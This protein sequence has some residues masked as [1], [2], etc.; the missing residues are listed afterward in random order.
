MSPMAISACL[1]PDPYLRTQ[2]NPDP[3]FRE[4]ED[5]VNILRLVAEQLDDP[6]RDYK[7]FDHGKRAR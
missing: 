2:L 1:D 4:E 3:C 7:K 5:R 6:L